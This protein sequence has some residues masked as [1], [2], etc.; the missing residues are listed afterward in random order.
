MPPNNVTPSGDGS[1]KGLHISTALSNALYDV[2][3]TST[4]NSGCGGTPC[5]GAGYVYTFPGALNIGP[6]GGDFHI[7]TGGDPNQNN[8]ITITNNPSVSLHALGLDNDISQ[9]RFSNDA[10]T[11]TPWENV[12]QAGSGVGSIGSCATPAGSPAHCARP[13][14]LPGSDGTKTVYVQYGIGTLGSPSATST[15]LTHS[16]KLDTVAPAAPSINAPTEGKLFIVNTNAPKITVSGLAE[17]GSTVKVYQGS[18]LLGSAL[19]GPTGEWGKL[20]T[21]TLGGHTIA[22]TATDQAANTSPPSALRHFTIKRPQAISTAFTFIE[23]VH[24]RLV[25]LKGAVAPVQSGKTVIL[26]LLIGRTWTNVAT[27]HQ[28]SLGRFAFTIRPRNIRDYF[29][30]FVTPA[31]AGHLA[32]I[33]RTIDV[34]SD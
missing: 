15:P 24:G 14:T 13:W 7:T 11:W 27:T 22:A 12:S 4:R 20:I 8:V 33:S 9:A 2:T 25:T 23:F 29:Y 18:T 5:T 30:R 3:M 34:D 26:Q 6:V 1:G 19:A 17:P 10:F 21:F 28:N 16:V 31:D 32:A